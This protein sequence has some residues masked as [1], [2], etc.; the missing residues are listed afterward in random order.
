MPNAA[1]S[2]GHRPKS[3]IKSAAPATA[4]IG[5][6][7]KAIWLSPIFMGKIQ[8]LA[9]LAPVARSVLNRQPSPIR[10]LCV[11]AERRGFVPLGLE[12]RLSLRRAPKFQW[13]LRHIRGS[14]G[15]LASNGESVRAQWRVLQIRFSTVDVAVVKSRLK[16]RKLLLGF[17]P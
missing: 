14:V 2:G 1:R 9:A 15:F 8:S 5:R 16:L 17:E 4:G 7:N 3:L 12:H 10:A 11:G 6:I 13:S